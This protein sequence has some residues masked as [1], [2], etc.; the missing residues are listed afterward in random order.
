[1]ERLRVYGED[2]GEEGRNRAGLTLSTAFVKGVE[3]DA[4]Q[5][6][7]DYRL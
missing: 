1:M 2:G 7:N 5:L 3:D 4:S 6:D